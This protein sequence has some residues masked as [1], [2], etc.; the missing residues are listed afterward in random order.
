MILDADGMLVLQYLDNVN[1]GTHPALVYDDC[2]TL[3]GGG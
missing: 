3:F 2:V 1:V